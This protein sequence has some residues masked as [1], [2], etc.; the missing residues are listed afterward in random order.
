MSADDLK[1]VRRAAKAR[2]DATARFRA[3]VLEAH[4]GGESLRSIA[5]AAGMSHVGV[6]KIVRSADEAEVANHY[7]G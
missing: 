4:G 7:G 2:R 6:L 5:E 1:A 3:A